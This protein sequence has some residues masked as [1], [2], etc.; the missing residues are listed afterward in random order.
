MRMLLVLLLLA[1]ASG[2]SVDPDRC[3]DAFSASE[4]KGI[5]CLA[6]QDAVLRFVREPQDPEQ[7]RERLAWFTSVQKTLEPLEDSDEVDARL[8]SFQ[9]T[10]PE[11]WK[12]Y[13]KQHFWA[14]RDTN[15]GLQVR[16]ELMKCGFRHAVS[17][18]E[19]ELAIRP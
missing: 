18:L 12:E 17:T 19:K 7:R 2:C 11:F 8:A 16:G 13:A 3:C 10:H 5:Y 1:A 14:G 6:H 15:L 9:K 4:D